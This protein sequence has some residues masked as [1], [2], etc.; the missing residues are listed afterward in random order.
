M[1]QLE[2]GRGRPVVLPPGE[3]LAQPHP[4][5]VPHGSRGL[6]AH[7]PA[8]RA[9][10]PDEVD[11]L[12]YLHVLGETRPGRLLAHHERGARDVGDARSRPDDAGPLAHVEGGTC[13]LIARQ[14]GAP[15][16]VG[17]DAR[18]DRAHRGVGE[19]RQQR[20]QPAR[21][22]DAVRVEKRHQRRFRRRQAGV[23][24]RSRPAVD[25]PPQHAGPGRSRGALDRGLVEGAVI[26]D[27]HTR[28]SCQPGQAAGQ[29]GVPVTDRD[30]HRH[31][32]LACWRGAVQRG[33]GDPGVEEAARQ[34]TGLRVVG[35]RRA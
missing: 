12:P 32:W 15:G 21:G 18:R 9:Q 19:V 28:R 7:P 2:R 1:A 27:D 6:V 31:L 34:R 24:G 29:L 17:H 13:A 33:M 25:R 8:G 10:P 14:P 3:P 5:L 35:Y 23:P 30:N 11:V 26:D 20:I 4:V 22:G 16:L